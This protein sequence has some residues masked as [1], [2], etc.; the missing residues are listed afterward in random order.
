MSDKDK[1]EFSD[2]QQA[3][4]DKLIGDARV[5]ARDKAVTDAKASQDKLAGKAETAALAAEAKWQ[6]LAGKHEARVKELEPFE[7]QAADYRKLITGMLDK[8][9]KAMGEAAKK[10]VKALPESMTALQKLD[11][12]NT[13]EE[14]FAATGDGVGTPKRPKNKTKGDTGVP[15]NKR[16]KTPLVA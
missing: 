14:L 3:L 1:I 15:L 2:E 5:K 13:N 10:A 16:M 4:V 9:V 7:G 6:E 12:L 11:W 8:Q